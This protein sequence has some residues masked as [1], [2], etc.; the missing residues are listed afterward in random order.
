[1][2]T[3]E[4][5]DNPKHLQ[6]SLDKLTLFSQRV[7]RKTNKES[8]RK[9]KAK[10]KLARL[11]GRVKNQLDDFLHKLSTRLVRENQSICLEDLN[12]KGMIKNHCLARSI[13]SAS[14]SKFVNMLQ[15]K[16]EWYDSNIIQIGRFDPSSKLCSCGVINHDLQLKDSS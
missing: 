1:L 5:V 7:N 13:S 6:K 8:N 15:Y 3:G 12:T 2:S 14:W 10:K 16:S 9:S 4:K 11:H